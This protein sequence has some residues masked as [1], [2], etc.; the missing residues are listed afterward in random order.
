MP[1]EIRHDSFDDLFA[2][3]VNRS[4]ELVPAANALMSGR[5]SYAALRSLH[6]GLSYDSGLPWQATCPP[7]QAPGVKR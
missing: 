3:S 2:A 6:G 1:D 4:K 5:G 7:S